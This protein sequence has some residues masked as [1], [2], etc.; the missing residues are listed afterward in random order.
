[1]QVLQRHQFD[2]EPSRGPDRIIDQLLELSRSVVAELSSQE[3]IAVGISCG[4]PLDA[5]RGIIQ[6]PPNLPGWNDIPITKFLQESLQVPVFLQNDANACAL[7]E[8][9]YGAGKGS[10]NMIFLTFGTGLG[11]GLILDDRLYEGI[12]GLAGE[13]GH[14]RLAEDGPEGYGKRG[15]FEGFCSGAGIVKLAR[16]IIQRKLD[17]GEQVALI[18]EDQ[19]KE[20]IS[21]KVLAE[22]AARGDETALEVFATSGKYLG[23]GLSILIDILNPER[24]VIGSVYARN[25]DYILATCQEVITREALPG[26]GAICQIIPA[27]LG[28]KVGDYACLS[29]AMT[30]KLESQWEPLKEMRDD[31]V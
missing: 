11:A 13:I 29:V 25:P 4:G 8:W 27:A 23:H 3:L 18:H 2:T 5:K 20:E 7:A 9:K 17:N 26:S 24:I 28:D 21:T 15:S 16:Q 19:Q 12:N 6:S 31:H 1:M 30:G 14:L 22:A 10:S